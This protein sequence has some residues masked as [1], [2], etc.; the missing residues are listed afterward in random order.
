[1]QQP[2][3]STPTSAADL[4]DEEFNQRLIAIFI[5][6]VRARRFNTEQVPDML[7]S[8][9]RC[10]PNPIASKRS[11]LAEFFSKSKIAGLSFQGC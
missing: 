10:G 11:I 8:L 6:G 7:S 4:S 1:M 9:C 2:I 5:E 3:S